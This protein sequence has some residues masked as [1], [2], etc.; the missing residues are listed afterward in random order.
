MHGPSG[1]PPD[2]PT[3]N[4][5]GVCKPEATHC[6]TETFDWLNILRQGGSGRFGFSQNAGKNT[7][8]DSVVQGAPDQ[9][10]QRIAWAFAQVF[11]VGGLKSGEN[12]KYQAFYDIFVRHPT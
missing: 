9:L 7:V 8:W 2:I 1:D 5:P 6:R 11:V 3:H 12:E 4:N 10:R